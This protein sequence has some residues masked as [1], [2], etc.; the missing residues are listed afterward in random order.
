MKKIFNTEIIKVACQQFFGVAFAVLFAVPAVAD[1][2]EIYVGNAGV[3]IEVKPNL[4]FIIDTS[5]SMRAKVQTALP[6]DI[7]HDYSAD[8]DADGNDACFVPGRVYF[9]SGTTPTNCATD[10]WFD[11][12][13]LVCDATAL[14]MFNTIPP[15]VVVGSPV[16]ISD[17]TVDTVDGDLE[18]INTRIISSVYDETTD[19]T[20]SIEEQVEVIMTGSNP[21]FTRTIIHHT[22]TTSTGPALGNGVYQDQIAQW[23]ENADPNRETWQDINN[24]QKNW[25]IECKADFNEKGA[26]TLSTNEK[27][28]ANLDEGPYTNVKAKSASWNGASGYVL[29]SA[30]YLN[31]VMVE[32]LLALADS[33]TRLDVVKDVTYNVVDSTNNINIGLMRFDSSSS[34]GG[35]EGGSVRY[36]VLDVTASRN[37]F[38]SRLKTMTHGGYTP[39]AETLYENYL[40]WAGKD[41]LYGNRASPSNSTGVTISGSGNNTYESPI[42]YTCQKNYNI[43]LSDG[44]A[45]R[46]NSADVLID[47]LD[48]VEGCGDAPTA[49]CLDELAKYMSTHDVYDG[50]DGVQTV[51]TYTVG[52]D[53]DHKLLR[54][55]AE[56]SGAKYYRANN[57]AQLTQVFNK[58]IAEILSVNTTFSA[59]AVSINAFNRTTHRNELYFTLFKPAIGPHWN[60]NLKRFKLQFDATGIPSIVDSQTP[61][62]NAINDKTGFFDDNAYSWWTDTSGSADGGEVSKGGAAAHITNTRTVY[63]YTGASAPNN[64]DLTTSSNRFVETNTSIT[65][66][67]L[68]I[69]ITDPVG[70]RDKVIRW[71]R[72]LDAYDDNGDGNT[73]DAR[74]LMGDP[75]HSEPALIQYAGPDNNPDITAY[76]ATNDGVLHAVDT[77]DGTE[78]FSFIPQ[79]M[80]KLQRVVAEDIAGNG[81]A[82]GLDGSVEALVIDNNTNGIIETGFGDK[83]YIFFG[84]RR[85]GSNYYAMDVT[86]RDKPVLMWVINGGT[87]DFAQLGQSWSNIQVKK[88]KYNAGEVDVAVFAGGYDTDQDSVTT[89]TPDSIGNAIYIVNA[90]TGQRL[91]WASSDSAADL[92]L[93]AMQYSIPARLKAVDVKGDGYLD[94]MY[95]GDM[96][97]Q[98]WRVDIVA[99]NDTLNNLVS[100][101]RMVDL[102][103]DASTA[104]NRRFYYPP[105][106]AFVAEPEKPPYLALAFSSG[107]RAHPLKRDNHDRIYMVRDPDIF[108]PPAAGT[109]SVPITEADLYDATADV[110]GTGT[111]DE[112]A[113]DVLILDSKKGW[114]VTLTEPSAG[115]VGEKGLA[116]AL[117][118]EGLM[119][120][121][122][123]I[124]QDRTSTSACEPADGVGRVYFLNLGDATPVYNFDT[125]VDGDERY[126]TKVGGGLPPGAVPIFTK[127]GSA[128][129]VGTETVENPID[130]KL[131]PLFWYER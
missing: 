48:G 107:Y 75:L 116:E 7:N 65:N 98:I 91:W 5:G 22:T 101:V 25:R 122:T 89:R 78:L 125:L 111:A 105:D 37:D 97:G 69:K 10:D 117:I 63:T 131:K 35:Y 12:S 60:G 118:I 23:K 82:Y 129:M 93:P 53:I 11:R 1:D 13:A 40:Y 99:G 29:Y 15:V 67:M 71:S 49:N 95:V 2:I 58:I 31:W 96:G 109:Y 72:G 30:N 47:G 56:D 55:T 46:D 104:D 76:V 27:Y 8:Q 124:P 51:S 32:P 83:V 61:P 119:V 26:N 42:K 108:D 34:Q 77:R 44:D 3:D 28:I 90:L 74:K 68:D 66:A 114:Y 59:P 106:V 81:K 80:L 41:V 100:A 86:D 84:Q 94:R 73:D 50:I 54:K 4:V 115:F 123:Y 92:V 19:T 102:A 121:T 38:K 21:G 20:T 127:D 128:I 85:G 88:I 16:E 70:F 57:A 14:P 36:P 43:Y 79:E 6:Y 126:A 9:S 87:G 112:K 110:I 113:A 45:T 39:L 33:P 18:G 52:F 64:V 103:A 62:Q 24:V 17:V 130:E 120:V